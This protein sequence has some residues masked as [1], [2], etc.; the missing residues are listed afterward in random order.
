MKRL[1]PVWLAVL[2]LSAAA[3][4]AEIGEVDQDIQSEALS[5]EALTA[6]AEEKFAENLAS[7]GGDRSA[8][9]EKTASYLRGLKEVREATVRG[10]DSILVIFKDGN[11]LLLMLGKNRL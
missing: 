7:L 5:P 9:T 2:L 6:K 11:E 8:A 1:F 4:T 10:S 3:C